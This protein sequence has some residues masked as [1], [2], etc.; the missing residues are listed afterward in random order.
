M[1][2]RTA[3]Q[4]EQTRAASAQMTQTASPTAAYA[5][6]MDFMRHEHQAASLGV[7]ADAW[8]PIALLNSAHYSTLLE[9][10]AISVSLAAKLESFK[11]L[12]AA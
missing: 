9:N 2:T 12:S 1:S 7:S 3:E 10:N 5:S 11:A 4:R 8:R 6:E